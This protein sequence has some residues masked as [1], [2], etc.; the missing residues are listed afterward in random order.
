MKRSW[1]I[2]ALAALVLV[3]ASVGANAVVHQGL[4]RHAQQHP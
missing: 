4:D 2:C 3:A 1:A